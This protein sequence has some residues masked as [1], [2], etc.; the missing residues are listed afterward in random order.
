MIRDEP[1]YLARQAATASRSGS[2]SSLQVGELDRWDICIAFHNQTLNPEGE[3]PSHRRSRLRHDQMPASASA[4]ELF[5]FP[6]MRE[7][8]LMSAE[9]LIGVVSAG[10]SVLGAVA[11]GLMGT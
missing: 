1:A 3:S 5:A 11:A 6:S 2:G 8:A 4:N 10:V 9:V 7:T